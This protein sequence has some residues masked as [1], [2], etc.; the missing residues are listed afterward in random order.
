[1]S[2][3]RRITTVFAL[4]AFLL[5]LPAETG[6]GDGGAGGWIIVPR[7]GS[8][9]EVRLSV[10]VPVAQGINLQLPGSGTAMVSF[11]EVGGAPATVFAPRG[12]LSISSSLLA[13]L[14]AAGV[15]V[16]ALRVAMPGLDPLSG[17][18]EI[19]NSGETAALTLY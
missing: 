19:D 10:V 14:H 6:G 13:E 11:A 8:S 17:R 2:A 5:P 1:M 9:T 3:W 16:L 4:V 18:L 12:R 7:K 15:R